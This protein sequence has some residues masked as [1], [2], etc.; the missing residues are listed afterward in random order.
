M[1]NTPLVSSFKAQVS[2]STQGPC[3][4]VCPPGAFGASCRSL[5]KETVSERGGAKQ[6]C[7]MRKGTFYLSP[8][9]HGFG[10]CWGISVRG[11]ATASSLACFQIL[12][13]SV[14]STLASLSF[15][16]P[17]SLPP[18]LYELSGVSHPRL[19]GEWFNCTLSSP[20]TCT[21]QIWL[22][23]TLYHRKKKHQQPI[24]YHI[25]GPTFKD[26][27]NRQP[28]IKTHSHTICPCCPC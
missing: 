18:F 9:W 28:L 20:S 26:I 8:L 21:F 11:S 6:R 22:S 4:A 19:L 5:V 23:V 16:S 3:V 10:Q 27:T 24:C 25:G 15:C 17:P 7:S 2:V 14:S 1:L 12:S 13:L